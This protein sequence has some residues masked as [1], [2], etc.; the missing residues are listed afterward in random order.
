VAAEIFQ[1]D[2]RTNVTKLIVTFHNSANAPK[3]WHKTKHI[4]LLATVFEPNACH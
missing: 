2:G 4:P 3:N 1:A